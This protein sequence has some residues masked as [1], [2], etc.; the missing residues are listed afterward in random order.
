[1]YRDA[2]FVLRKWNNLN[3]NI[4]FSI[5]VSNKRFKYRN[6]NETKEARENRKYL[7]KFQSN[8]PKRA[9]MPKLYYKKMAKVFD[10]KSKWNRTDGI[11]T[12]EAVESYNFNRLIGTLLNLEH[13]L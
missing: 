9:A 6:D 2:V 13:N 8:K 7:N 10:E 3:R 1:M 4:S 5:Q 12:R 11:E